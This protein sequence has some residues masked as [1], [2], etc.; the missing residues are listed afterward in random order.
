MKL[1]NRLSNKI[2]P[3]N[4]TIEEWQVLLLSGLPYQ[5]PRYL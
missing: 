2:C 3:D 5:W 1:G 4:M